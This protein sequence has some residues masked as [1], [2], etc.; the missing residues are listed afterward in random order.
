MPDALDRLG[1][2]RLVAV[3]RA[4]SAETVAPTVAALAAGGIRA[5]ELTF[6]TPGVE[7]ALARVRGEHPELLLGAGTV[8][9]AE[10]A[11]A[12]ADAGAEFLVMPH[13]DVG[14][15]DACVATGLPVVPGALTASEVAAALDAG[16]RAVKLFPAGPLGIGYMRALAGPFPGVPFVPTGGIGLDDLRDWLAAGAHAVGVGGELCSRELIVAARFDELTE[17]A[18]R[19]A[20]AAA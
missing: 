1:D 12:A 15:V 13:L 16:A 5:V 2:A 4:D 14:L 19:F 6:T 10:Q 20:E 8:R 18:R 11:R 7:D 17:L 9:T 3:L